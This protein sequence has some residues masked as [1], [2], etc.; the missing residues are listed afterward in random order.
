MRDKLRT[1]KDINGNPIRDLSEFN[2][3]YKGSFE[4]KFVNIKKLNKNEKKVYDLT[5]SIFNLVG[6]KPKI[7]K[8]VKISETMISTMSSMIDVV[9]VWEAPYIII[10]R[11]ELQDIESYARTLLHEA[12]HASSGAED[13]NRDFE[14]ELSEFLGMVAEKA[15]SK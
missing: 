6:G 10:K 9:G 15:L 12:A 11:T 8:G 5:N 3:E 2:K 7:I 14:L 13:V 1:L 4:F